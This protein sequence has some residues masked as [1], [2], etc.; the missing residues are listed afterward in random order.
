MQDTYDPTT[1]FD[2]HLAKSEWATLT[3]LLA[4][5]LAELNEHLD[6]V[7]GLLVMAAALKD[8]E[9]SLVQLNYLE[10]YN[11]ARVLINERLKL[12]SKENELSDKVLLDIGY[13]VEYLEGMPG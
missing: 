13:P 7:R 12:T 8:E 10:M 11:L 5:S 2:I 3:G 6:Q 1:L 4:R 9:E